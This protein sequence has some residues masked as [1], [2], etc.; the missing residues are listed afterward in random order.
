[1]KRSTWILGA[2]LGLLLVAACQ[3]GKQNPSV[4]G[5]GGATTP[6]VTRAKSQS[7]APDPCSLLEPSEAEAVMGPLATPPFRSSDRGVPE[8]SGRACTYLTGDFRSITLEPTWHD[9]ST[10]LK[11]VS[12]PGRITSGVQEG[13]GN[14]PEDAPTREDLQNI[15]KSLL[16]NG[17]RIDGEWDEAQVLGCCM[18]YALRGDRLIAFDFEGWK[19][20]PPAAAGLLNK[21]LLRLERPSAYDGA[22]AVPAARERNKARPTVR[23]ACSL[24]TRA[25][26]EAV[27][28][29]LLADPR[30][31]SSENVCKYRFRTEAAAE[32]PLSHAPQQ[33]REL[34]S[35]IYG[36]QGGFAPGPLDIEVTLQ[37][38]DGF[39]LLAANQQVAG[40]MTGMTSLPGVAQPPPV[41]AGE[42]PWQE[43]AQYPLLFTAV[44]N[45]AAVSVGTAMQPKDTVLKL[46]GLVAKFIEKI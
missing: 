41:A 10:V 12:L 28:G 22:A 15:H 26:V 23:V 40:A 37:W 1:M 24:L 38:R 13:V 2:A 45:D 35:S 34:A 33:V 25:E 8:E 6:A 32:G 17:V 36:G 39:R 19:N 7:G 16:A 46:R 29:P 9:G 44:K 3:R 42:G 14:R 5:A 4:D 21:A 18:I 43:A 20:D 30:P 31:G 11:A 27:L